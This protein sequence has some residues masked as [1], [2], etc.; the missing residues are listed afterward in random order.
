MRNIVR[1]KI[2]FN[3]LLVGKLFAQSTDP[4]NEPECFEGRGM[5]S[6]RKRMEIG[7]D[8]AGRIQEI[9]HLF[10]SLARRS[11]NR[12]FCILQSECE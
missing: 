8:F 5:Q 2:D 6:M 9:V 11:A 7:A 3:T 12:F 4:R 1:K 10:D